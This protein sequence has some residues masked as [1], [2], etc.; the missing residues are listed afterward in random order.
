MKEKAV[1]LLED[2]IEKYSWLWN[3]E[4]PLK[5]D[6]EGTLNKE[7]IEKLLNKKFKKT[8]KYWRGDWGQKWGKTKKKKKLIEKLYFINFLLSTKHN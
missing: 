5:Q 6:V 3:V 1:K 8:N 7:S 2:E 4:I